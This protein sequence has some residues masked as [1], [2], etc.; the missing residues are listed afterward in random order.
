[1]APTSAAV[2][3]G[4]SARGRTGASLAATGLA[5]TKACTRSAI[6]AGSRMSHVVGELEI[7]VVQPGIDVGAIAPEALG[8]AEALDTAPR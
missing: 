6:V 7:P 5:M 4:L 8:D 1:M 2:G 3:L